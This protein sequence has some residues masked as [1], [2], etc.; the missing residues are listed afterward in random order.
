MPSLSFRPDN[1]FRI[2]QFTDLHWQNGEPVDVRTSALMEMALDAER[3]DLAV[4][5]GDV[6]DGMR[7][8]DPAW[9]WRQA[10]AP[11]VARGVP[12]AGVFG[13]HD[14]EGTLSRHELL[15]VDRSHDLSV[16]SDSTGISGVANYRLMVGRTALWFFDSHSYAPERLG[17]YDWIKRDQI[18]WYLSHDAS[19][20]AL[21]F[22]HIPLPEYDDVW[23]QHPCRG[24]KFETVAAPR[25]N[26]GVFA[27][28]VERGDVSGV[29]A[30]HDHINDFD[31]ELH[32]I[33]LC[34]GRATGYNT[35]GKDGFARGARIIELK[36]GERGFR[37]WLRLEDGS[38]LSEQP[39]HEPNG[40]TLTQETTM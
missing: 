23:D 17:G 11:M 32:G 21:A 15:R 16:T 34:Y 40:R 20:N 2:I 25:I 18:A 24:L 31:G 13:N 29:F 37:S 1:A 30:G 12:W 38:V 35:Y 4:L 5:T 28:F 27:A 22:L 9:S 8:K 19:D 6:I 33:R 26:T 39:L 10:V 3:P 36:E 14:D 7:C